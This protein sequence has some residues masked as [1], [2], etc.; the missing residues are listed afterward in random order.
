MIIAQLHS[1]L[2]NQLF[3]YAAARV[4]SQKLNTPLK[5]DITSFT[6]DSLYQYELAPFNI[7]A[8]FATE[9]EVNAAV[10]LPVK[11]LPRLLLRL[12]NRLL[13]PNRRRT[14]VRETEYHFTNEL[15]QATQNCYLAGLWQSEKYFMERSDLMRTEF[16]LKSEIRDDRPD[17]V[18]EVLTT[19]AVSLVVRRGDYLRHP[20]LNLYGEDLSYHYNALEL[21]NSRVTNPHYFIFSDDIDW[22]KANLKITKPHTF[23]S[24]PYP[25]EVYKINPRRH[26][27]LMLMSRCR[28]HIITNSTFAWWGAWLNPAPDKIVVA[29]KRWFKEGNRIYNKVA[30]TRDVIPE[31]WIQL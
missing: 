27:D 30:D 14:I 13:P 15:A 21:I 5:L 26:L 11:M 7:D 17:L 16:S 22:V 2:G 25:G 19:E 6:S 31:K 9:Q 10:N 23:V 24:E 4:V 18:H 12:Q 8:T 20:D 1:G 29:P 3:Q 28:H